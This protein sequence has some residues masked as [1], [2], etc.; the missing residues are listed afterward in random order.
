MV[1]EMLVPVVFFVIYSV[2]NACTT[3][4]VGKKASADGSVFATHSNDGSGTTDPRLVKIPA[5][6]HA[7]GSMR[8]IYSSP[9]GYPR[10]VGY[11]R[12]APIYFSENC[13]ALECSFS[14]VS[15]PMFATKYS[16][17]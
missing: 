13:Q 10:Y 14:S 15:K 9:E 17:F 4:G 11:D 8:P 6:D 1:R 7:P 16:F 12:E 2:C 5:R 3:F